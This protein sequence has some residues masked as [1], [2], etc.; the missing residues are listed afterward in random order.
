MGYYRGR[1]LVRRLAAMQQNLQPEVAARS[2]VPLLALE[3]S[4]RVDVRYATANN[5]L[6]R[7]VYPPTGRDNVWLQRPAAEVHRAPATRA[8]AAR[9]TPPSARLQRLCRTR[10]I[11]RPIV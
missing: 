11:G 4:L 8:A 1:R 9:A 7:A 2:L 3:P 6:G 10:T 5:F